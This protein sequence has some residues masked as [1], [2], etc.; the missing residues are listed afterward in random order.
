MLLLMLM[1]LLSM[2]LLLQLQQLLLLLLLLLPLILRLMLLLLLLHLLFPLSFLLPGRH[3]GTLPLR[4]KL[5][6]LL[7][8]SYTRTPVDVLLLSLSLLN[9]AFLVSGGRGP[10]WGPPDP[11]SRHCQALPALEA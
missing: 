1:L 10:P 7:H 2:L 3:P 5:I 6:N 9:F 4:C 8:H 11:G